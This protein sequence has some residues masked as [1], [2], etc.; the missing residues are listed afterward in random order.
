MVTGAAAKALSKL[1]TRWIAGCPLPPGTSGAASAEAARSNW[2]G[3]R[4]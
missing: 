1:P 3:E 4:A 2:P